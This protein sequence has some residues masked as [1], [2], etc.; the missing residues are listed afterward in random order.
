MTVLSFILLFL[1]YI[2]FCILL[3]FKGD[4][5]SDCGMKFPFWINDKH[6][7]CQLQLPLKDSCAVAVDLFGARTQR[8]PTK[9][10][11]IYCSITSQVCIYGGNI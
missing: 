10:A 4:G 11:A 5:R 1:F 6:T 8:C 7:R 2:I 9:H 3:L